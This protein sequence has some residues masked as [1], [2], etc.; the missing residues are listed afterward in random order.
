MFSLENIRKIIEKIEHEKVINETTLLEQQEGY[1]EKRIPLTD[2]TKGYLNFLGWL[3]VGTSIGVLSVIFNFLLFSWLL[4]LELNPKPFVSFKMT[5]NVSMPSSYI[6]SDK[7]INEGAGLRKEEA[8]KD[9]KKIT[10]MPKEEPILKPEKTQNKTIEVQN[11]N[12][13][14]RHSYIIQVG[15]FKDHFRANI[16]KT[17]LIKMGFNAY[18]SNGNLEKNGRFSKLYK[19][20][21]GEFRRREEAEKLS[22]KIYKDQGLQVFLFMK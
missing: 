19:V 13:S 3:L 15:A 2:K 9:L 8:D 21:I 10:I 22:M 12:N 6:F 17:K 1:L 7:L 14:E 5:K 20:C 4:H 11:Y 18:I 16:L